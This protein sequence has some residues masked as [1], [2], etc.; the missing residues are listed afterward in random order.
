MRKPSI[1]IGS[2]KEGL[3][4]AKAIQQ[5]LD[6]SAYVTLWTQNV[7][8]LSAT[9]IETLIKSL[10]KYEFAIFIFTPDDY[11]N[12]RGNLYSTVRD[13][14]IFETGLFIG[15]LGKEKVFFITPKG[16]SDLHLPTDLLGVIKGEYDP[17]WPNG[18]LVAATGAFC[19]Q[20]EKQI[21]EVLNEISVT[22]SNGR[23]NISNDFELFKVHLVHNNLEAISFERIKDIIHPDFTEEYMMKMI[24]QFPTLIKRTK[25]KY[26]KYGIKRLFS[27]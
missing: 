8:N 18:N 10:N 21:D 9:I 12:I 16:Q 13:N 14:V 7:F 23:S 5:N 19:S 3:N 27:F 26:G 6:P 17:N 11:T 24:E 15:K 25:L 1:F 20:V 4:V 22:K 2:S